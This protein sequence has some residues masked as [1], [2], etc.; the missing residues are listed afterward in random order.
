MVCRSAAFWQTP[1]GVPQK[2]A[3]AGRRCGDSGYNSAIMSVL[4]A[5]GLCVRVLAEAIAPLV[6]PRGA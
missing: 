5:A 4:A 6:L 2:S 1:A 3:L